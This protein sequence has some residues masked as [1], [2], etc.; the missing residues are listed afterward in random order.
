MEYKVVYTIETSN[1]K[2]IENRESEVA[3]LIKQGWKPIGGIC[4]GDQDAAQAMIKE[5]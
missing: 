4:I 1:R 5:D 3:K 2:A